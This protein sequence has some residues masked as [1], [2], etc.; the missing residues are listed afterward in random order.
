MKHRN[1]N[2][3]EQSTEYIYQADITL[4][5]HKLLFCY[6]FSLMQGKSEPKGKSE[7]IKIWEN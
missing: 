1:K 7:Q 5:N 6:P 4:V 2:F 3:R